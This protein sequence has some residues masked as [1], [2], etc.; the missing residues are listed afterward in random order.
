MTFTANRI[1][2]GLFQGSRPPVGDYLRRKGFN[3]LVLC[4]EEHQPPASSFPGVEV[5]HAP[6]DDDFERLPTR[7]ELRVAL[8]AARRAT[9]VL[10]SGG[11]VLSTCFAGRNRSGLV[12]GL[13]LHLW[14]GCPGSE[15]IRMIQAAR[16]KALRNPGF[17]TVL[18][19]LRALE[20]S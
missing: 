13:A 10:A 4:A 14:L 19:R 20:K 18:G 8:Q 1:H 12:S 6:N 7:D 9:A 17:Q 5:L 2:R 15:A 3:L 16:P 11:S